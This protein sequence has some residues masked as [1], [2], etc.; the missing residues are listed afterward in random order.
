MCFV[1]SAVFLKI[2][3]RPVWFLVTPWILTLLAPLFTGFPRKQY[4]RGMPFPSPVIQV[5]LGGKTIL[6]QIMVNTCHYIFV[7][8]RGTLQHKSESKYAYWKYTLTSKT[9][10]RIWLNNI[11]ILQMYETTS[12][13]SPVLCPM[14]MNGFAKLKAKEK[15]TTIQ[16]IVYFLL[17]IKVN[18]HDT[19]IHVYLN[20]TI[21]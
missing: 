1:W 15:R 10:C 9:E 11:I 5:L 12:L 14:E 19:V 21:E 2:T 3:K 6:F 4:W 17:G 7:K 16:F 13:R 18:N 8:T 20:S